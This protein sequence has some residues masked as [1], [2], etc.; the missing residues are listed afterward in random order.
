MAAT[1]FSLKRLHALCDPAPCLQSSWRVGLTRCTQHLTNFI[2]RLSCLKIRGETT[3]RLFVLNQDG[4]FIGSGT[5]FLV[6]FRRV[7]VCFSRA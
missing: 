4:A 6:S 3:D 2:H 7:T 1:A 5:L